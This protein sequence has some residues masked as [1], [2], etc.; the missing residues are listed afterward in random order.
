MNFLHRYI[1]VLNLIDKQMSVIIM[2]ARS[3]QKSSM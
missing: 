1:Q 2:P 3:E